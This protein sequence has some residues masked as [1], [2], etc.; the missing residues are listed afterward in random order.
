M[1]IREHGTLKLQPAGAGGVHPYH[2]ILYIDSGD[3][4]LQWMGRRYKLAYPVLLVIPAHTPHWLTPCASGVRGWYMEADIRQDL[5][6]G[7]EVILQWNQMQS[8]ADRIAWSRTLA[9]GVAGVT[10]VIASYEAG[11]LG[12][13]T[14]HQLLECDIRKLLLLVRSAVAVSAHTASSQDSNPSMPP[15]ERH[16][17]PLLR[18]MERFYTDNITIEDL[19]RMCNLTPSYVIRL[20]KQTFGATPIQYLQELRLK[21]AISYLGS[22][23]LP[24]QQIAELTGFSNLHYFSRMFKM[25]VGESPSTWRKRR[26]AHGPLLPIAQGYDSWR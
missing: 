15:V 13:H 4:E 12:S 10:S 14:V 25:K 24:V 23:D 20:F 26:A 7:Y 21:A 16:L 18:Y 19:S 9:A 5:L 8:G 6:P 1:L 11:E 3:S 22:T 17:Y 2:E